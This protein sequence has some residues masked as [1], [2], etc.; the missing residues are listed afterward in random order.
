[1]LTKA[2]IRDTIIGWGAG[3]AR[4]LALRRDMWISCG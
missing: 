3:Y 2:K 1:L 4:C